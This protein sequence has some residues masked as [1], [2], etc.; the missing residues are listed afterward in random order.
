MSPSQ[1]QPLL[2]Q[3]TGWKVAD[4]HHLTKT[5]DFPDFM[6]ALAFV[7]TLG[8]LAEDE[9]HHPD[10]HLAWGK[11]GVEIYTHKVNGLTESD[12]ILAAK[13]DELPR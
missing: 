6:S 11:V 12:F 3:L 1:Y 4:G 5:Y 13:I 7:N 10:I 8:E 2:A 9:G